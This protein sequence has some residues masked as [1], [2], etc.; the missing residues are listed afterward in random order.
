MVAWGVLS[1]TIPPEN[2]DTVTGK[3]AW[4]SLGTESVATGPGQEITLKIYLQSPQ[5]ADDAAAEAV[6]GEA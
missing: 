5:Q 1:L 3:L 2:E 4:H 6:A